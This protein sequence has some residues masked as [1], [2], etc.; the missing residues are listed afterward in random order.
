MWS[1]KQKKQNDMD[2]IEIQKKKTRAL[3]KLKRESKCAQVFVTLEEVLRE[4]KWNLSLFHWHSP[5][6]HDTGRLIL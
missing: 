5:L 4:K 3:L 2:K 6:Q 1:I